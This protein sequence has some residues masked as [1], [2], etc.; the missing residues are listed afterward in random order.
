HIA[1]RKICD[2]LAIIALILFPDRDAVSDDVIDITGPHRRRKA[3]ITHLH[4]G[5]PA[6]QDLRAASAGEAHKIDGDVDLRVAKQG[7]DIGIG[8]AANIEKALTPSR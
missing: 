8:A 4:G 6:R 2:L 1:V 5:W 3:K 7:C